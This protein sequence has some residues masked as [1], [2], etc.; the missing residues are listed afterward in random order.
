MSYN[1]LSPLISADPREALHQTPLGPVPSSS[2]ASTASSVIPQ[3]D[4]TNQVQQPDSNSPHAA[5]I[6]PLS[7]SKST[8]FSTI[9]ESDILAKF[10][11][12]DDL[13]SHVNMVIFGHNQHQF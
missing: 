3:F 8:D 4:H 5:D 2:Q 9:S 10:A 1:K 11:L 6:P 13:Q 7:S 12:D